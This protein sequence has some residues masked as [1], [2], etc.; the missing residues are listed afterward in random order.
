MIEKKHHLILVSIIATGLFCLL[1]SVAG[2]VIGHGSNFFYSLTIA[3]CIGYSINFF[4][5]CGFVWLHNKVPD[6]IIILIGLGL[7]MV[8][9]LGLSGWI[10]HES[11]DYFLL[12]NLD[13]LASSAF[14]GFLGALI[15]NG[16]YSLVRAQL[17]LRAAKVK[18]LEQ[19]KQIV[20]A[21]LRTLQAQ[22]EPH[23]LFNTLAN[24]ISL[25]ETEPPLAVKTLESLTTL[26]RGTLQNSRTENLTVAD[27]LKLIRAYL[28]IQK[29]RLGDRLNYVI[30]CED[31]LAQHPLSPMLLQP[32]VENAVLHGIEPNADGG[33]INV[34]VYSLQK[35]SED[36]IVI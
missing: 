34:D 8:T 27:E 15:I 9:G 30:Q 13:V 36:Y 29:I 35:E 18:Q 23:F 28:D 25:I 4:T 7:G 22:I 20:E 26:L 21:E 31:N 5:V 33:E 1:I 16:I 19:E 24:T 6:L 2:P 10:L 3:L 11:I 17:D 32:I 14:F 12:E